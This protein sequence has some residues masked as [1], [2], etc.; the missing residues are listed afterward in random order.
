[1]LGMRQFLQ[2]FEVQSTGMPWRG[3]L[4]EMEA[5]WCYGLLIKISYTEDPE[6]LDQC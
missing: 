6:S 3:P 2:L 5:R 1:M 4:A